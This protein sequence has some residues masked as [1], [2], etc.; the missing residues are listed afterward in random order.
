MFKWKCSRNILELEDRC[1]YR[2]PV[3]YQINAAFTIPDGWDISNANVPLPPVTSDHFPYCP[4]CDHFM[5]PAILFNDENGCKVQK[6]RAHDFLS[7]GRTDL[8]L[9]VGTSGQ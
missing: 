6:K 7:T 8:M 4:I 3:T 9:V 2:R 1:N 5:R